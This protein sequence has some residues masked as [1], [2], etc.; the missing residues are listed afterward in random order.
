[1]QSAVRFVVKGR[2]PLGILEYTAIQKGTTVLVFE[3]RRI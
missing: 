3:S 1:M 2:R